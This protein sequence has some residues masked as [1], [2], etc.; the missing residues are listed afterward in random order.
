MTYSEAGTW[1]VSFLG[2]PATAGIITV[3]FI[4]QSTFMQCCQFD[5]S[6][7]SFWGICLLIQVDIHFNE[8]ALN[9]SVP[10]LNLN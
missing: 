3:E 6:A 5:L 9:I 10:I 2:S 4:N 8:I 7:F 1:P